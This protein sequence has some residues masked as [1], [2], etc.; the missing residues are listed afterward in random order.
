VAAGVALATGEFVSALA[1]GGGSLVGGVGNEVVDRA[2]GGSVRFA[3]DVFGTANKAALVTTVIGVALLIGAAAGRLSLR[4]A[5]VGPAV[6]AAFGAVGLVAGVRDPLTEPGWVVAATV[7]AVLGGWATLSIL[8]RVART[9]AVLPVATTADIERPDEGKASRRA[10]FGWAGAAGTF[11][12]AMAVGARSLQGHSRA[13]T[14]RRQVQLPGV[15]GEL[16][17]AENFDVEGLTPYIV[18]NDR[19]Y[20]IDTALVIP[21]VDVDSWT[22]SVTGLV[23][24]PLEL[25]FDE[26]LALPMVEQVVT[27]ACVSNDVGGSLVGN[28]AWQ[29]VPLQT[30]LDMAGVQPGATQLVG[31]SV[32]GFTAGFPTEVAL[33]G[34]AALL[35]VGMN[36]EPLP[37]R[38]GFP[39]RL[40]VAGLYGYVSAT[41]WLEEIRLTGWDDFDGY[42]IPRGWSKEGPVKTQARIDVPRSGVGLQ[43][44]VTPIAGIAWAPTKGIRR[45]EVQVDEGPWRA[46]T[47]GDAVSDATW[48]QWVLDW[49]APPGDHVIRVRATDGTGATQTEERSSVIPDGA[50]GWHSR[51]VTVR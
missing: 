51:S 22:L 5:W 6:F 9:D 14:A 4:R 44:G 36:G 33:D 47:I 42:W 49:D 8:L 21:Q 13:E 24:T 48:V 27:L 45:V 7:A 34:R 40:V 11:A 26:L 41:K 43:P 10:F 20:R 32:D 28:A 17:P 35:A 38:H 39:A 1:P 37:I 2:A 23:D 15:V 50:T 25:T 30:V 31:V 16:V 46:A 29:G 12:G 18:P 3:I 19:F